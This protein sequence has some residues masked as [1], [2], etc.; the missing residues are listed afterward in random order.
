MLQDL[1]F[2]AEH[3]IDLFDPVDAA[4]LG[5]LLENL[6]INFLEVSNANKTIFAYYNGQLKLISTSA[7]S[8]VLESDGDDTASSTL[9]QHSYSIPVEVSQIKLNADESSLYLISTK[10]SE[11]SVSSIDIPILLR[12]NY[13]EIAIATYPKGSKVLSFYP[14][15]SS[16][17]LAVSLLDSGEIY[18][19]DSSNNSSTQIASN[20]SAVNW[21]NNLV[22]FSSNDST[23]V[24]FFDIS[25]KSNTSSFEISD[26]PP[27]DKV[28]YL[29]Q[30]DEST[31]L[32]ITGDSIGAEDSQEYTSFFVTLDPAK[33]SLLK[34]ESTTSLFCSYG[35]IPRMASFYT[36]IL[37]NWSPKYPE[38]F[39]S[40]GSKSID[41][42]FF[43]KNQTV[44]LLND[45]DRATMPMDDDSG[46]DDTPLGAVLDFTS[47]VKVQPSKNVDELGPWPRLAILTNR[48]QLVC[49]NLWAKTD[50]SL[51]NP[52]DLSKAT[53]KPTNATIQHSFPTSTKTTSH[54]VPTFGA[55]P[56][57][58]VSNPFGSTN[59][60]IFAQNSSFKTNSNTTTS[61]IFGKSS[62]TDKSSNPFGQSPFMNASNSNKTKS[63][64][65]AKQTSSFGFGSFAS[66]LPKPDA[67]TTGKPAATTTANTTAPAAAPFGS[68]S[69]GS[70]FGKSTFG[71][72]NF[73]MGG[74]STT[75]A[76]TPAT[77]T[78]TNTMTSKAFSGASGGFAAFS[79]TS[80][81]TTSSPFGQ[82]SKGTSS[83]GG[84]FNDMGKQNSST[85]SPFSQLSSDKAGGLFS[86]STNTP[87][88][89]FG[90][91]T[92]SD[93]KS[94]FANLSSGVT[95]PPSAFTSNKSNLFGSATSKVLG[96]KKEESSP[97]SRL[98]KDFSSV[99]NT[100]TPAFTNNT[101]PTLSFE[102]KQKIEELESD[103]EEEE[104]EAESEKESEEESDISDEFDDADSFVDLGEPTNLK[105]DSKIQ[106]K[107]SPGTVSVSELS[108]P[109]TKP[110]FEP[111]KPAIKPA[112][113]ALK[114]AINPAFQSPKNTFNA[115]LEPPKSV[116]KPLSP[117][118]SKQ[119]STGAERPSP[120][121]INATNKSQKIPL[122]LDEQVDEFDFDFE[123]NS[124]ITTEKAVKNLLARSNITFEGAEKSYKDFIIDRAK[125]YDET[126]EDID[127][128]VT[129]WE[130]KREK[131]KSNEFKEAEEVRQKERQKR[132]QLF[133]QKKEK[134]D[135]ALKEVTEG[136]KRISENLSKEVERRRA[137]VAELFEQR[138][139]ENEM[140]AKLKEEEENFDV[141]LKLMTAQMEEMSNL[142]QE[143]ERLMVEAANEEA[144]RLKAFQKK[145]VSYKLKDEKEN[146]KK[147]QP[148]EISDSFVN[149]A[150]MEAEQQNGSSNPLA[151]PNASVLDSINAEDEDEDEAEKLELSFED[152]DSAD[153][154]E[155]LEEEQEN[156]EDQAE[157][158]REPV[159]ETS[160]D[161]V[162][163]KE[164]DSTQLNVKVNHTADNFS[165]ESANKDIDNSAERF[166][167]DLIN[168]SAE[169]QDHTSTYSEHYSSYADEEGADSGIV[170][171]PIVSE[172]PTEELNGENSI[173]S[174]EKTSDRDS[175]KRQESLTDSAG[176][177]EVSTALNFSSSN[178]KDEGD[179]KYDLSENTEESMPK[180]VDNDEQFEL[181][182]KDGT[183]SK[184]PQTDDPSEFVGQTNDGY[185]SESA[186]KDEPTFETQN[187]QKPSKLTSMYAEVNEQD[188]DS[189]PSS[190]VATSSTTNPNITLEKS[191]HTDLSSSNVSTIPTMENSHTYTDY[192]YIET[193]IDAHTDIEK[194]ITA[195]TDVVSDSVLAIPEY[196]TTSTEIEKME[197]GKVSN[198]EDDEV[199]FSKHYVPMTL[200]LLHAR[201]KVTYPDNF[202]LLPP[203]GKE[204]KRLIYD[205]FIDFDVL[206][207]NIIAM[208]EYISDQ[209]N[210]SLI[211]HTLEKSSGFSNFWRFFEV[212]TVL[213][214]VEKQAKVY[215]DLA[216]HYAGLGI[217]SSALKQDLF[218]KFRKLSEYQD[219]LNKLA[220]K[221]SEFKRSYLNSNRPLTFE[222]IKTRRNLREKV[223]VLQ[224]ID[225]TVQSEVLILKSQIY[226]EQIVKD[227]RLIN[228][229]ISSLQS[230]LYSHADTIT[231]LF[232]GMKELKEVEEGPKAISFKEEEIRNISLSEITKE[233]TTRMS[234]MLTR[235]SAQKSLAHIL[236]NKANNNRYIS[237]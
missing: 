235:I 109:A 24:H 171:E 54:S 118:I 226:P 33:L 110:A 132:L 122:T 72:N 213:Q 14:S 124:N 56:G 196:T 175:E 25:T 223:K 88:G 37:K 65:D 55:T 205:V 12:G 173:D 68:T 219:S 78:T 105:N 114:P 7:L 233:P 140:D 107:A 232:D 38:L 52:T 221:E 100:N 192:V 170:Q 76:A 191:T 137:E 17:T 62:F 53:S 119:I 150:N 64:T 231:S 218:T 172:K 10:N 121:A 89:L 73:K 81:N 155:T 138:E 135:V 57:A 200:P 147:S 15:P 120:G 95:S 133:L 146:L 45:S 69:F 63:T 224:D 35:A 96:V 209:S 217:D 123:L 5:P 139:I 75:T 184:L 156:F 3:P 59:S 125:Y 21:F 106:P 174:S 136:M 176:D 32:T 236:K 113:G 167:D 129:E 222:N 183:T 143:Q 51:Y 26:T 50:A 61:S 161:E 160:E 188:F 9:A 94:P 77:S 207:K 208:N 164:T 225:R 66:A 185:E 6:T 101:K 82:F 40:V 202:E 166:S 206:H 203:L 144:E 193:S 204:M 84:L 134:R 36:L 212:E 181:V 141:A 97:F 162:S 163:R 142:A 85:S 195:N 23:V 180:K 220:K 189:E 201:G 13:N 187:K 131:E 214:G 157:P 237:L 128:M 67:N 177:G 179:I 71:V 154:K 86:G 211:F 8:T 227:D 58:D 126:L 99:V 41:I 108:K 79:S 47:S 80:S 48:G 2:Q 44:E 148:S 70:S 43:L 169:Q 4:E 127:K 19:I 199:Y 112:F 153:E 103:Y 215:S 93:Q 228:S 90:S 115:A 111:S 130:E 186:V 158:F 229:I 190:K 74:E 11:T 34:L 168:A 27:D 92:G 16:P 18:L 159:N 198:F 151:E 39:V 98:G 234:N 83:T 28:Y 230:N 46:D 216:R 29:Q 31:L 60:S 91:N 102:T 1:G 104:L 152:T 117:S 87:S 145:S 165:S 182:D 210:N 178:E 42:D 149:I 22:I 49:W 20:A 194:T 30:L 197:V 116:L